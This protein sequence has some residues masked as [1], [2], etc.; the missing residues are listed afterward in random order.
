M[1]E[2][3]VSASGVPYTISRITQFHTLLDQLFTLLT[4]RRWL[5]MIPL[6]RQAYAQ[7]IAP[8]DA[9][10]LLLPHILAPPAGRLPDI[11]GPEILSFEDMI[12]Q[13]ATVTGK[14]RPI[15]QLPVLG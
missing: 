3:I 9:A 14:H 5:P 12:A 10:A 13:W 6:P 7:T 1:T 11:G 15:W 4:S 2:E 8:T